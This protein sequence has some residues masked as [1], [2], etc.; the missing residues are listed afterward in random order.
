M[1]LLVLHKILIAST[2]VMGVLLAAWA[3]YDYRHTANTVSLAVGAAGVVVSVGL[4]FYYRTIDRR[5]RAIRDREGGG[6]GGT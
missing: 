6:M 5:Y 4:L 3:V 2:A 1:R